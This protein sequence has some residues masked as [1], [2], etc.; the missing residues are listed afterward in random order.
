MSGPWA[1]ARTGVVELEEGGRA[2]PYN[3]DMF[4]RYVEYAEG[5]EGNEDSLNDIDDS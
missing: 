4:I 3:V 1:N 2:S 5:P